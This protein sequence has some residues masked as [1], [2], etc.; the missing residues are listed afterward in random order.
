[1]EEKFT[2]IINVDEIRSLFIEDCEEYGEKF[3]E[4]NFQEFLKFLKIDFCDWIKG[5][6]KYF[7]QQQQK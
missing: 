4:K 5:N 2:T 3:I 1:M 7:Y 6:L